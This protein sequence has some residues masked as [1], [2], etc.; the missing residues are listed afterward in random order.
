VYLAAI[1]PRNVALAAEIADGI[2]ASFFSPEKADVVF[3]PSLRAGFETAGETDKAQRFDIVAPARVIVT[4]DVAAGRDLIRPQ[5]AL[6]IGGMGS[7]GANFY[8]DLAVRYGYEEVAH[9]VQGAYLAGD[10]KTACAAIP[11]AMVDE[12]SLVGP[13]DRLRTSLEAWRA[14]PATALSVSVEDRTS[15]EGLID[16]LS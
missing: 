11:D 4:D 10:R 1:G 14:S 13:V 12:V 16:A 8:H 6:Y 15:L 5:L 3:G 7:K 2:L 9:R